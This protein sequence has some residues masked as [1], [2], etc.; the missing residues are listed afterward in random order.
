MAERLFL[1]GL[2]GSLGMGKSETAK[3][4]AKLGI[5][6]YDSDAAVHRLYEPGGAAVPEIEKAFPG[7]V[8]DGAVDL[9]PRSAAPSPPIRTGSGGWRPSSIR[10]SPVN[11]RSSANRR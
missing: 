8:R 6:V 1:V 7:T 4:F 3:M 2:T 11:R 9:A 5:P 10:W